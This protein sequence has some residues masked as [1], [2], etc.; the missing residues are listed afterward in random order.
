MSPWLKVLLFC[1]TAAALAL[2]WG[3]W[4]SMSHASLNIRVDDYAMDAD[5]IADR[6][7]HDV[8]VV[9][10]DQAHEQLA[11]ARSVEPQGFIL[12]VHPNAG[13][14]NCQQ[15]LGLRAA[16]YAACYQEHS[17]WA[18]SWAP[19]VRTVDVTVGACTLRQAPLSVHESNNEWWL[20][21]VPHPHVG[22]IP[23]RHFQFVVKIDSRACLAVVE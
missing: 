17:A 6:T 10:R 11:Q 16:H 18:S 8:T 9:F 20:W 12:A 23:R 2:A 1:T 21:W 14:G 19:K 5:R 22:G 3:Y 13:I 4:H 7:P 15:R